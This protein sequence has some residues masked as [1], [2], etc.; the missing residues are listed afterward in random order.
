MKAEA[1]FL[2]AYEAYADAIF[3]YTLVRIRNRD[4]A[5]DIVQETFLRVW[6]YLVEKGDITYMKSFLYTVATRLIINEAKRR[7]AESL[8]ALLEASGLED[9][10][11]GEDVLQKR[12]DFLDGE[13]AISE[14]ESL[15]PKDA[16]VIRLRFIAE[17]G[18][19]EIAEII[20]ETENTVS[21]RINRALKKLRIRLSNI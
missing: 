5:K 6:Q 20:G 11:S 14:L 12:V 10:P 8:E 3:R 18:P 21:V 15:E 13:R 16:E 4:K 2:A 19:K 7:K 17:C 1:D 9:M